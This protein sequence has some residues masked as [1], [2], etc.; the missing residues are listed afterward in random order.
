MNVNYFHA[1]PDLS[2]FFK[3]LQIQ[4]SQLP[5]CSGSTLFSSLLVDT[6]SL[7]TD[8]NLG[9]IQCIVYKIIQSFYFLRNASHIY[10]CTHPNPLLMVLAETSTF[11]IFRGR[12]VRGQNVRA[13][14]S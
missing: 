8:K 1:E 3:T 5:T 6:R 13:E 4:I 12:N 14:T 9:E 11:D 2:F 10:A 7:I